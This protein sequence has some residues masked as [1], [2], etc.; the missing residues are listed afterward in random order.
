[1][2]LATTRAV[3]PRVR[4]ARADFM[5]AGLGF[6]LAGGVAKDSRVSS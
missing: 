2:L 5:V 3:R 1:M 6:G 4:I